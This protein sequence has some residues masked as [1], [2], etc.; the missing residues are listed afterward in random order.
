MGQPKTTANDSS[1][2]DY[3]AQ[4]EDES[5]R[6]DAAKLSQLMQSV[7]GEPATMWGTSIVG[8]GTV[9]YKYASGREGDTLVVGL[10]ARKNALTVYGL[11]YHDLNAPL[12]KKL[13][14]VTSGKG[15]VYIK[16]LEDIDLTVLAKMIEVAYKHH[17]NLVS[18]F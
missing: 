11:L 5:R 14:K 6:A 8:F 17:S 13:G 18:G 16:S 9:H 2:S 4:I 3:L 12:A 10:A 1:V 7:T 15:C